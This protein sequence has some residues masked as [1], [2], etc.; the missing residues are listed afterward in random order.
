MAIW[1]TRSGCCARTATGHAATAPPTNEMKSRR[2]MPAPHTQSL[3]LCDG[4][5]RENLHPTGLRQLD[6]AQ[7]LSWVKL[8]SPDAQPVSRLLQERTSSAQPLRSDS[9]DT[10]QVFERLVQAR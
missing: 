3:A 10:D 1:R 7:C 5:A 9:I 8:R 4:A 6:Q 2:C